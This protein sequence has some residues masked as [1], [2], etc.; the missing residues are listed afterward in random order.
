[1]KKRPWIAAGL[2]TA[3]LSFPGSGLSRSHSVD[4]ALGCLIGI[5]SWR[6]AR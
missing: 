2:H 1:M 3:G 4:M 5:I 6:A